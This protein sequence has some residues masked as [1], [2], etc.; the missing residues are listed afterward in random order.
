MID[1]NFYVRA[2]TQHHILYST[3]VERVSS[4]RRD[5]GAQQ[6]SFMLSS[7][8]PALPLLPAGRHDQ[9]VNDN[10]FLFWAMDGRGAGEEHWVKDVKFS[11]SRRR[12][13]RVLRRNMLR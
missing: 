13:D 6:C 2:D 3:C 11:A 12:Y 4:K 5:R 1:T 7:T 10:A 8:T 9:Q